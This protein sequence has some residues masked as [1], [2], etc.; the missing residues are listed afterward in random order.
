MYAKGEPELQVLSCKRLANEWMVYVSYNYFNDE[1]KWSEVAQSCLTLCDPMDCS[2]SG[3][4]VHGI[5][6]ARML[7]WI[8]IS[9]SRG[10]SRY[11]ALISVLIYGSSVGPSCVT[12]EDTCLRVLEKLRWDGIQ[13]TRKSVFFVKNRDTA[14]IFTCRDLEHMLWISWQNW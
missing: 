8:A 12:L 11:P 14:F 3:S 2:L 6:Q 9:F 5:F 1:V 10:L 7:E 4:S 13:Y